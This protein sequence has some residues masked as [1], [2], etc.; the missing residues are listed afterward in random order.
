MNRYRHAL[1]FGFVCAL[2]FL[3]LATIAFAQGDPAGG[4]PIV[5]PADPALSMQVAITEGGEPVIVTTNP[6]TPPDS[7]AQVGVFIAK[8]V[9]QYPWIA[10]LIAF[11]GT[12]RVWAKLAQVAIRNWVAS[13][14]SKADDQ[15]LD[16]VEQSW[17]Y[18]A[19]G[20]LVDYLTS[21]KLPPQKASKSNGGFPGGGAALG[22]VLCI[23]LMGCQSDPE[24][25]AFK[26]IASVQATVKTSMAAWAD[27][28]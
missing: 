3:L 11:I 1:F 22:L 19:L 24:T 8:L 12:N 7:G 13:T 23:G 27:H 20:F 26:T 6:L 2:P 25:R 9:L 28:V 16:R 18:S 17:W 5:V 4:P 14:P 21:I 15:F 10:A